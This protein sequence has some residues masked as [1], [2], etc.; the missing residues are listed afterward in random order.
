[1]S[2]SYR[3]TAK[4]WSGKTIRGRLTAA[5]TGEAL[6]QLHQRNLIT[7]D[8]KEESALSSALQDYGRKMLFA[9]GYR[10]YSSRDMM[11]FCRQFAT[12]LKTGVSVLQS[13]HILSGQKEIARMQPEI[14]AAAMEIEQG[15]SL[16][17][18]LRSRPGSFPGVMINMVDAGEASGTIGTVMVKLADHFEK[19]HDFREKIRSA[20][21]YPLFMVLVSIAVMLVMIMFVLPQFAQIFDTMGMEMPFFTRILLSVSGMAG[22]YMALL[23]CAFACAAALTY[24]LAKTDKGKQKLDRLRLSLP[25]FGKLY[26]QAMAA[27]YARTMAALLASGVN[28]HS[29]L[30]MTDR[31]VN[32]TV[33]S[34][35]IYKLSEALSRGEPLA[36]SM[37]KEASF[38]P[39]LAEMVRVGEETGALD[40]TLYDTALF[41]EQEVA[42]VVD[43]LSSIIEPAML[44]L[45]GLFIGILV[46]SIFSPMY[47]V[48]EMI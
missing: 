6:E 41:Y 5:G 15:S 11:I 36:A 43:R 47:Q 16:A 34:Q 48:F 29:A 18:A 4:E 27:R 24:R 2:L 31:V 8:L 3:F 37:K 26:R 46:F 7:I 20:T 35:S 44:L 17:N 19:Q 32:N 42:Y 21:L 25:F 1:M 10:P 30:E 40:Q 45:V 23:I 22:D 14:R 9:A 33:I 13:L 39:L 28:L 12:M 38:P